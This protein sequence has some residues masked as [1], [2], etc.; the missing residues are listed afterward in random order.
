MNVTF[1]TF[2]KKLNSTARPSGG[3]TYNCVLKSESSKSRPYIELG[4]GAT[5]DPTGFNYCYIP[6]YGRYYYVSDWTWSNGKWSA[7]MSVDVLAS[8]KTEI[9][10]T[11]LYILRASED[12]DGDVLD[13]I[14]PAKAGGITETQLIT[15]PFTS[16]YEYGSYVVGVVSP[17]A[18]SGAVAYYVLSYG[19]MAALRSFMMSQT[20]MP[21]WDTDWNTEFPQLTGEAIKALIN[22]FQY[23]ASCMWL[24]F[25]MYAGGSAP[26]DF[27]YWS[28][29]L[30]FPTLRAD[31]WYHAIQLTVPDNFMDTDYA[32][33]RQ[34]PYGSYQLMIQPFGCVDLDASYMCKESQLSIQ[35][36]VDPIN[37][38]GKMLVWG[39]STNHLY[40]V[41]NAQVGVSVQLAQMSTDVLG[42]A[43]VTANSIG[44]VV[45]SALGGDLIGA[46]T[47]TISGIGDI[48]Q[49]ATPTLSTGGSNGGVGALAGQNRFTAYFR[50]MVDDDN[51]T[52]GRP[53]CK[54]NTAAQLG[55]Y[56]MAQNGSKV[57]CAGTLEEKQEIKNY[58]ET[59]FYYE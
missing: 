36:Y 39:S 51:Q 28:S 48:A 54:V 57:S 49:A 41:V 59:G 19:Q 56:I 50:N 53:L 29:G 26:M 44:G 35:I 52:F 9:G 38:H 47:G 4:G 58:I 25:A 11:S 15:S 40:A 16:D 34:A 46:I 14:Y 27:G 7:V 21:A 10:S 32:W 3:T 43:S 20:A 55:G 5:S 33:R 6:T 18:A 45:K 2:S 24:P 1:Y 8:F 12:C 37:G 17:S 31:V 42:A 22:P 23:V 30:S 13:T